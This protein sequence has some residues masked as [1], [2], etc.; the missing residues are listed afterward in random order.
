LPFAWW[1]DL[2]GEVVLEASPRRRE[3]R[4]KIGRWHLHNA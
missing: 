2:Q 1:V 3:D 4:I